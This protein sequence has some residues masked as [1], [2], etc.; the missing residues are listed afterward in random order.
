MNSEPERPT[1]RIETHEGVGEL[2]P[3]AWNRL[4]GDGSP[5]LDHGFLSLLEETGCTGHEAGWLPMI[6]TA[7][8]I[9]ADA[10]EDAPGELVGALPIYIKTNSAGEFVFD[11]GWADAAHRAGI[12]YYPKAVVAVPF[13]PVTGTRLLVDPEDPLADELSRALVG[14]ALGMA[15]RSGLSSVHFNFVLEREVAALEHAGLPTRF[16]MQYHWYNGEERGE[17]GPYPDFDAFLQRFRAKRRANIR[18]ERRK[19][20]ESGV[21]VRAVQGDAI[22]EALMDHVFRCY[23][24]TV[25]KFHWGRQYLNRE[26]FLRLPE[27]ARDHLHIVV[28][29]DGR[30]D[31]AAAFNM[32]KAGRLYGRYWGCTREVPFAHFEVCMYYP[33]EWCIQNGVGVFEPGAGGEHKY[34]RG[35]EPTKTFS[36]HYIVEPALDHAIRDFL[37]RERDGVDGRIAYMNDTS[38]L[39]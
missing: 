17:Q 29:S 23:K 10:A 6:L 22:D 31:F 18:R 11:W 13:T 12:P 27:R 2:D 1:I 28:A 30:G 38:V 15:K 36:A 24:S 7:T 34:E 32:L 19:L 39:K 8:R 37:A 4:V 21:R 3:D 9:P 5:F 25:D 14:A 33:I 16:G 20:A 35:F 26:F